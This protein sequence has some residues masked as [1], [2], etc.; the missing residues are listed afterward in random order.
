MEDLTKQHKKEITAWLKK[1]NKDFEAGFELYTRFG[2]NRALALQ[3]NRKKLLSKLVYEL[4]KISD[5]PVIRESRVWPIGAIQKAVQKTVAARELKQAKK[6]RKTVVQV[7]DADKIVSDKLNELESDAGDIVSDKL[8]ELENDSEQVIENAKIEIEEIIQGKLKI[9]SNGKEINFNELPPSL[10]TKWEENRD[11][12]KLMRAVHEKMKLAQTDE[13]RA[14]HRAE[15]VELDDKIAANWKDIDNFATNITGIETGDSETAET[16]DIIPTPAELAKDLNACRSFI[17]RNIQKVATLEGKKKEE[18][19]KKLA[20]RTA[21]L[22][23]YNAEMREET[24]AELVKLELL[25][26]NRGNS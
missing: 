7:K 26:E 11:S 17:S 3:M 23:K 9:I 20:E 25:D 13:E 8:S 15:L 19:L 24:R 18:L 16:R 6:D 14:K 10:Q 4:Q 22:L 2:H 1:K 5:Q 21:V 12:Y